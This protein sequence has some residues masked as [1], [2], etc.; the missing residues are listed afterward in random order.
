MI[1]TQNTRRTVSVPSSVPSPIIT[2]SLVCQPIVFTCSVLVFE[3]FLSFAFLSLCYSD[4]TISSVK[5]GCGSIMVTVNLVFL[6]AFLT[7]TLFYRFHTNKQKDVS[8]IQCVLVFM[9]GGGNSGGHGIQDIQSV[10]ISKESF[11]TPYFLL[12]KVQLFSVW[13]ITTPTL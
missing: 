3:V 13:G 4:N 11:C 2:L 7:N 1:D 12:S 9:K 8:R 6:V 5:H 10:D